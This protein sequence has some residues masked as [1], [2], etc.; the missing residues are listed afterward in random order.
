MVFLGGC[1]YIGG[2]FSADRNENRLYE[3]KRRHLD[4]VVDEGAGA[5]LNFRVVCCFRQGVCMCHRIVR[6][7]PSKFA[8]NILILRSQS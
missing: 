3:R 1:W 4:D 8:A 2:G 5:F 7:R 6:G